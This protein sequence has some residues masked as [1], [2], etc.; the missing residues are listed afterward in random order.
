MQLLPSPVAVV[1]ILLK[2][3]GGGGGAAEAAPPRPPVCPSSGGVAPPPRTVHSV[4]TLQGNMS[5]CSLDTVNGV[6]CSWLLTASRVMVSAV[7]GQ[8]GLTGPG[9]A[10]PAQVWTIID[11]SQ[12]SLWS[13]PPQWLR[14]SPPPK[15]CPVALCC[16]MVQLQDRQH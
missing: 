14:Y 16:M 4:L 6:L 8:P 1:V 5:V 7:P 15:W 11:V 3:G 12:W 10:P 2:C 13:P 9:L